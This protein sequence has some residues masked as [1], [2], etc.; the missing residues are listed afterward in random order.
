M[1]YSK[2]DRDKDR[3]LVFWFYWLALGAA[4]VGPY[5]WSNF[6]AL[7]TFWLVVSAI[8]DHLWGTKTWRCPHAC[9]FTYEA[10]HDMTTAHEIDVR[11]AHYRYMHGGDQ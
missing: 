5:D 8:R 2:E 1:R 6:L 3:Y 7:A 9:G 10:A 11:G 4:L